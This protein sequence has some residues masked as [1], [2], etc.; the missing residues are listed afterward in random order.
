MASKADFKQEMDEIP[1]ATASSTSIPI[2]GSKETFP[3]KD[4]V[5]QHGEDASSITASESAAP[6]PAQLY[7]K[8]PPKQFVLIM[9]ALSLCVFLASLDQIIVSTSIPAITKEYNSLGDISWLATAYMMT[10]TAFQPL[11]GKF[12]DIFG[13]KATMLFANV[14]FLIGS[15]IA[16]WATSMTM[17]IIGRGVAGMGAGGLMAMVFIIL[18]DMLDMR[19][20]G[21]YLGF[22]GAIFSFSS[23]V[24]PLLGGAFTDHLTWRWSFWI[25]LPFGAISIL[26]IT[27]NLNLPTPAGSLSEKLK[28]IDYLGS[29]LLMATVILILLPLSWG[30]DKYAWNSGIVIGLLCAAIV[31][32]TIFVVVEWKVPKEPIIPIHLFRVRNLWSTYGSLFFSG[33]SFFGILFY[34]PVYFQVI[35]KES[36]TIGGLETVPFVIGIVITSISSGIWVLKRGTFAF[37]P[38]LGNA[39]FILGAALCILFQKDTPRVATIFI[40]LICGLGMGFTMQASTLAVQAAVNPK[41]MA[42]VTTSVQFVRSLGQVFGV[43]IVGTV[44]NNKLHSALIENFPGDQSIFKVT[45]NY[46]LIHD[47]APEQVLTIYDSYVHALHYVFYCSVAFCGLAFIMSCFIQHK[48]LKTN[49]NHGKPEMSVEMV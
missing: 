32:G 6:A 49:A 35:K 38:A 25:N 19:E 12:S 13:R 30:G 39:F 40:L 31:V 33:M 5:D 4:K 21:K 37:F 1:A 23:V 28:R 3:V 15:A 26:F 27:V 36:A 41:Y 9:I 17:L 47:Y 24:G 48:E 46:D 43:A 42:T 2:P 20:R 7:H 45:Q 18:S 34:L 10:A 8:P 44:F 16:G 22:I 14:V 11:Y 29:L